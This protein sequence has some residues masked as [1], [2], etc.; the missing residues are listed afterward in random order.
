MGELTGMD[1]KKIWNQSKDK[2][3]PHQ[4]MLTESLFKAAVA[5]TFAGF[6]GIKN[7]YTI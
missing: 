5:M 2:M 6:A 7:A 3:P 1:C 4:A